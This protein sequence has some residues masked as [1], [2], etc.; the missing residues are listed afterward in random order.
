MDPDENLRESLLV[1][2][3]VL[4]AIDGDEPMTEGLLD[5]A[6]RLAELVQG[7]DAWLRG[8]GFLPA[9]WRRKR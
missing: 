7:L 1:A 5:D 6:A 2:A 8:G 9:S 3:D 4:K